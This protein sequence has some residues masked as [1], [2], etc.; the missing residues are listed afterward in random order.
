MIEEQSSEE[1]T[2]I[3][4]L[5]LKYDEKHRREIEKPET[6]QPR[7]TVLGTKDLE[8][9]KQFLLEKDVWDVV[10]WQLYKDLDD[11]S[12]KMKS[13]SQRHYTLLTE[14]V[15]LSDHW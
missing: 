1:K 6:I 3:H 9:L 10:F 15:S 13:I 14:E 5:K 11:K 12:V 2:K 8:L 4:K 7:K